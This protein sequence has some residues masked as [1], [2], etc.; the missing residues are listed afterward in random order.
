MLRD[1][2]NNAREKKVAR[3]HRGSNQRRDACPTEVDANGISINSLREPSFLP[4]TFSL[5]RVRS[6]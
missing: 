5:L 2:C 1:R 6:I 3:S 4:R